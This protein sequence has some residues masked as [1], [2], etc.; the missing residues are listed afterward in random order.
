MNT[1]EISSKTRIPLEEFC[2]KSSAYVEITLNYPR[3]T[4]FIKET[5]IKQRKRYASYLDIIRCTFGLHNCTEYETQYETC[6]SGHIHSHSLF[7][8]EFPTAH[9]PRGVIADIVKTYLA[10]LPKKYQLYKDCNM[11]LKYNKYKSPAICIQYIDSTDTNRISVW[12]KYM[13]K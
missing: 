1:K 12:E 11:D 13:R 5:T 3:T 7:K 4:A 9:F 2:P 8:Y 6:Q 10:L